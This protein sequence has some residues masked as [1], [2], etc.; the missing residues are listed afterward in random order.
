MWQPF[1]LGFL[2]ISWSFK[3]VRLS[4]TTLLNYSALTTAKTTFY[5]FPQFVQYIKVQNLNKINFLENCIVKVTKSQSLAILTL[6][7]RMMRRYR[8]GPVASAA[9]MAEIPFTLAVGKSWESIFY[10]RAAIFTNRWEVYMNSV[11]SM[12]YVHVRCSNCMRSTF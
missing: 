11:A 7:L 3:T 12:H 9:I 10:F 1:L 2:L 8:L 6:K 4:K 5:N